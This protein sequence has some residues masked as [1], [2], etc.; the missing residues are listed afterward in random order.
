MNPIVR[1][2]F[3][4]LVD[5]VWQAATDSQQVPDSRWA[6]D[7]IDKW[8]KESGFSD[9]TPGHGPPSAAERRAEER[10]RLQTQITYKGFA[11]NV[12]SQWGVDSLRRAI[13]RDGNA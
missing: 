10:E 13:E 3:R 8:A 7:I 4:N 11:Y 2:K 1:Q 9:D 12:R 6:D 5:D